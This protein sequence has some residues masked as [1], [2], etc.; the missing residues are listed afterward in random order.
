[1]SE[2]AVTGLDVD[3]LIAGVVRQARGRDEVLDQPVQIVV[4]QH[5]DAGRHAAIQDRIRDGGERFGPIEDIRSRP[6]ARMRQLQAD[7]QIAVGVGAEP[8]T[9]RA[10]QRFAQIGDRF[11]ILRCQQQL[12]GIGAAVVPYR[13]GFPAPHQFRAAQAEV[14][15]PPDRQLG[16]LP[17]RR[18]VPPLHRQHAETVA[19]PN[20]VHLER[21]RQR[22]LLRRHQLIVEVERNTVPREV[23]AKCG[24]RLQGSDARERFGHE[25]F[26]NE[27]EFLNRRLGDTNSIQWLS[28]NHTGPSGNRYWCRESGL[29]VML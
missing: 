25:Q 3:E 7:E 1:M 6:A 19:H 2:I 13:D 20:A 17:I 15:P 4:R 5:R 11:V 12:I 21:L 26:L 24:S 23:I 9:M 16:G 22:G 28:P 18:P 27:D 8:F 10:D 14:A 29:I